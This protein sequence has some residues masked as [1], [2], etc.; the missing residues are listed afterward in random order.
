MRRS[1]LNVLQNALAAA[2]TCG[3]VFSAVPVRA[4]TA[5]PHAGHRPA[6]VDP[7]AGHRMPARSP[8]GALAAMATTG[9]PLRTSS[10][11]PGAMLSGSPKEIFLALPHAMTL[12]TLVLTNA[13]GQRIPLA[14]TLPE[15]P[16]E[17]IRST[18]PALPPGIYTVGW[19]GG[20]DGHIMAGSFGFMVH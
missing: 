15:G 13:V 6:A 1:E 17:T 19:S 16:V 10:P 18:T 12:R 9:T 14:A 7:H 2:A 5:D 20:S 3:L 8:G 4:Q 11:A